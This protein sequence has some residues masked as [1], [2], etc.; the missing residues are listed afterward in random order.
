MKE[1][2]SLLKEIFDKSP[3]NYFQIDQVSSIGGDI[4][5]EQLSTIRH[6]GAFSSV[7][8][9]FISCCI[10]CK[11][12]GKSDIVKQWLDDCIDNILKLKYNQYITRRSAGIPF[13]ITAILTSEVE[14]NKK[15]KKFS[16]VLIEYTIDKLL[17]IS[18]LSIDSIESNDANNDST[19]EAVVV[20]L[21]KID[22]P[23]VNAINCIR[24][25]FIE[26]SLS[27][28]SIFFIDK[29]LDLCLSQFDSPIWSIRNCSVMLFSALQNKLFGCKKRKKMNLNS[30]D[31]VKPL[32]V[33][34]ITNIETLNNLP[35]V[36]S[37]LFFSKFKDTK[38]ILHKNLKGSNEQL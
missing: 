22:L 37:R 18:K 34:S 16:L 12:Y 23:Q 3:S 31:S 5:I 14:Y 26:S 6:R 15:S 2:S 36:P 27:D 25:I 8:P 32:T 4:L 9:T 21:D 29:V 38:E 24:S 13:L 7:Y 20:K 33:Y 35:T 30:E 11:T 10:R 1:S 19:N 17:N 28:V